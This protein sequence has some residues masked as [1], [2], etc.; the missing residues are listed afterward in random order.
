MLLTRNPISEAIE[1]IAGTTGRVVVLVEPDADGRGVAELEAV[2]LREGDA[3]VLCD[4]D[5]PDAP[6]RCGSRWPRRRRTS[7]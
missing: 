7:R 4:H 5:A 2:A 6:R 3:V 1:L